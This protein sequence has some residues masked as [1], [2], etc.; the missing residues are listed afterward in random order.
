[1]ELRKFLAS[2][3]PWVEK[4]FQDAQLDRELGPMGTDWLDA[5]LA[6]RNGVQLVA[7]VETK[8]VALIGCVW[9]DAEHPSHYITDIAVDPDL[10][11]QGIASRALHLVSD[12]PGHPPTA[13]WTAFVAS[14]NIPA[15]GLLRK[16]LWSHAG[17][18]DG[19]LKF[20]K[21]ATRPTS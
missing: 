1:M 19:M 20:E 3:W 11:E 21:S 5:V 9:G 2:D 12:W 6:E 13:K 16:S 10:R 18:S 17:S 4:W 7:T 8:P 14:R 15:Q